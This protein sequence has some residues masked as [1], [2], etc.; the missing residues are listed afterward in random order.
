MT[1]LK[2]GPLFLEPKGGTRPGW[3]LFL[4]KKAPK[5]GRWNEKLVGWHT[6]LPQCISHAREWLL[7]HDESIVGVESLLEALRRLERQIERLADEIR[8]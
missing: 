2:L 4:L 6:D 5:G 8:K 1:L 3:K 7:T